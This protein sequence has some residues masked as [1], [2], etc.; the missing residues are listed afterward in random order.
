MEFFT[1]VF[2]DMWYNLTQFEGG[3]V[4]LFLGLGALIYALIMGFATTTWPTTGGGDA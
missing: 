3:F 1:Q 2:A 4:A